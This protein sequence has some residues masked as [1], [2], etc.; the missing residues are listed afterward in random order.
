MREF[1]TA[2]DVARGF[3]RSLG[4]FNA[5]RAALEARG[6]PKPADGCGR[7]WDPAAIA[8]WQDAQL[9]PQDAN[10]EAAAEALLIERAQRMANAA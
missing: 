4:W 5:N 8:R 3:R 1:L 9:P 6:F 10:P 2:A 7:R